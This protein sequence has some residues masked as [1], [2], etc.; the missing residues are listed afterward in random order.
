LY[1]THSINSPGPDN[2]DI[3]NAQ[4]GNPT[5]RFGQIEHSPASGNQ[6]QEFV[7]LLNPNGTAVDI[8]NWRIEGGITYTFRPGTV[9]PAG[10]SLYISPS[11]PDFLARTSGPRGGQNLFV[12]G[13]YSN[14]IANGAEIIRL[15]AADNSLIA[16]TAPPLPGDYDA[17]GI[18]D[19]ADYTVWRA[20]FGSTNSLAADGSGNGIVDLADYVVWRK[21]LTPP[22]AAAVVN[23]AAPPERPAE[24]AMGSLADAG[25]VIGM[26]LADLFRVPRIGTELSDVLSDRP[27]MEAT[28]EDDSLLMALPGRLMRP[29][30]APASAANAST[31]TDEDGLSTI[32]ELFAELSLAP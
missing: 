14:H 3:P 10:G 26:A 30:S 22:G 15:V 27:L 29:M 12:Q 19:Q 23:T 21:N 31:S 24:N 20:T 6:N 5:I 28:N 11:V 1:V 4:I 32:D 8:S 17:S 18:V 2:A 25:E 16:Q 13:N 9:I 7:Q